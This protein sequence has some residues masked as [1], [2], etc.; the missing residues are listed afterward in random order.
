[1][2]RSPSLFLLAIIQAMAISPAVALETRLV[3]V[4]NDRWVEV[5]G[6]GSVSATPDFARVTLGVATTGKEA[7]EAMAANAK[8]ANAL[9]SLIKSEGVS[10]TDIQTSGLSIS[11]IFVNQPSAQTGTATITGYSVSNSVTVDVRDIS[12]LGALLDKAV[13]AGANAVYGISFGTIRALL[14]R[15]LSARRRRRQAQGRDLRHGRGREGRSA[16]GAHRR[17]RR[18]PCRHG[19]AKLC[20]GRGSA[21][22]NRG[23]TGQA[24]SHCEG[25]VRT[26][27]V[28][29]PSDPAVQNSL[30]HRCILAHSCMLWFPHQTR[31]GASAKRLGLSRSPTH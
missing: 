10:P 17:G 30:A 29:T 18:P 19:R 13:A 11:P 25:A 22:A 24:D 1:M 8:A 7:R 14:D 27:A 5:S 16:H 3:D 15:A 20:S 9:V 23:R 21:D 28:N 6:E 12:R 31:E 4:T 2:R 26:D